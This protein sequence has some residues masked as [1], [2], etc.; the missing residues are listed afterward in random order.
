MKFAKASV[1][2]PSKSTVKGLQA[3]VDKLL[4]LAGRKNL[5]IKIVQ[6]V[7]DLAKGLK[8][9]RSTINGKVQGAFD[10]NTGTIYLVADNVGTNQAWPVILHEAIHKNREE[11]GWAKVFGPESTDIMERIDG[12]LQA[13]DTVWKAAENTAIKEGQSLKNKLEKS[14]VFDQDRWDAIIREETITYFMANKANSSLPL[15]KRIVNAIRAWAVK[16]GIYRNITDADIVALA[17][18]AVLRRARQEVDLVVGDGGLPLLSRETVTDEAEATAAYEE[19]KDL[20][21]GV[22]DVRKLEGE[23]EKRNF[24]NQLKEALGEKKFNELVKDHDKAIQIYMDLKRNPDHLEMFYDELTK[25]QQRIVDLSQNLPA[26]VLAVAEQIRASYDSLGIE[27]L[28]EEVIGNVLENYAGRIWDI[29]RE[30]Q[31]TRGEVGRKFGAKTRHA[32]QRKFDTILEGWSSVDREGEAKKPMVLKV[33]SATNSLQI[34][35]EEINKTI[36]D[37]RFIKALQKIVDED[38]NKLLTT[39]PPRDLHYVE[40]E[41]P[42]FTVWKYVGTVKGGTT[43]ASVITEDGKEIKLGKNFMAGIAHAVISKEDPKDVKLFRSKVLAALDLKRKGKD[44]FVEERTTLLERKKLYAPK[45]QAENL[46][47]ILGIS[48]LANTPGFHTATKYNAIFKSWILQSSFFHHLAFMR[49]Y[50]LGTNKKKWAEMNI[51]T[52]YREGIKSIELMSPVVVLGVENGLTLGIRQD[53]SE[54]LLREKTIIGEVLDKTKATK[55]VKD[56]I[57]QLREMQSDFLFGEF[58]AGLKAKSFII[59]FRNQKKKHPG[60]SDKRVATRVAKLINDDFGGLHLGRLGRNPTLQHLFRLVALA[61]DWTES[62]I[63]SMVKVF[64]R[65]D[66]AE[67]EMYQHFWAG[68]FTKGAIA[69]GFLNFL[70]AGGDLDEMKENF[71]RAWEEGNLKWTKVD[72]TPIYKLLGGETMRR[73]YFSVLGHFTDPLKFASHLLRSGHHKGSVLYGLVYEMFA[74]TDWKGQRF[75]TL[76]ELFNEGKTVKWGPG[77]VIDYAQIPSFTVSQ[78]IGLQPVQVQNLIAWS[79]GEMEGFDALG[80]S[81]GLGITSTYGR[82]DD[83]VTVPKSRPRP[84]ARPKPKARPRPRPI[85]RPRRKQS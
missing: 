70:L 45:K 73:K 15:W 54:E 29:D 64:K 50:F 30:G 4:T 34:V 61:P 72:I 39:S 27:A 48:K 11:G 16:Y 66:E 52:A 7:D 3:R 35:K 85:T 19:Q 24:Q 32:K 23:V 8:P 36:A 46:N 82:D 31:P 67:R 17:E 43:T 21:F 26:K 47:N 51:R 25:E 60:H 42:N 59:E 28:S 62:N 55:V 53:W 41:H 10:P 74:G 14:G 78:I 80:N 37:K 33:N 79:L 75:T 65:G 12:K 20:W 68:I 81:M 18:R 22:K 76:S 9:I 13:D 1:T 84:A 2:G 63:R 71:E 49:S 5:K 69:T 83:V 40:V 6:N 44:Y 57:L 58:G 56:K 77:G 38:G